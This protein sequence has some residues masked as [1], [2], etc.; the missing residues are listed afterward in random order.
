MKIFLLSPINSV[1]TQRWVTALSKNNV[2]IFLFSVHG[3]EMDYIK[4]LPNVNFYI[5]KSELN[6]ESQLIK[7]IKYLSIIKT[8][9]RKISEFN[10]DII[11]SHYA[12]SYGLLGAL[13]GFHPYIISIWGSDIYK[14]PN[15]S[16]INRLIIKNNLKKADKVLS[17]SHIMAKEAKKYTNKKIEITPFGVDIDLFKK[18][19]KPYNN[20]FIIGNVKTL[21]KNYGIDVL[22]KSF[23]IVVERNPGLKLKLQIIGEGPDE[24]KLKVLSENLGINEKIDFLGKI[25]NSS[26]P[27]YYNTFDIAV[28]LSNSESFGVVAIEAMA[29][30]CPVV[31]SNADGFTEVVEDNKTGFIVPKN[32]AQ[33]AAVAIQKFIDN[34]KLIDKF[35]ENG[36]KRVETL[37]N[38]DE[39][40]KTMIK[41]YTSFLESKS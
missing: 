19:S 29:C 37:Y 24:G 31:V 14:F 8:L 40:V 5:F 41:I 35:G 9:K 16:F 26:L 23:K 7:K 13:T 36:R 2:E 1:H 10:P 25:E 21:S 18:K 22:I 11:H 3:K 32:N 15:Y 27:N 17:T 33:A 30:E 20:T 39:N 38:W 4:K 34:S 12:S 6:A 28:S